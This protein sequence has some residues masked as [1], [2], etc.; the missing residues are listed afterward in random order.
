MSVYVYE[1]KKSQPKTGENS[2]SSPHTVGVPEGT[3]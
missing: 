1:L 2:S 3:M